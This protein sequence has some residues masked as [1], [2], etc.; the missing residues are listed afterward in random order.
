M[1]PIYKKTSYLFDLIIKVN[2]EPVGII[3][4][5]VTCYIGKDYNMQTP[6]ISLIGTVDL[7]FTGKVSFEF[8]PELTDIDAGQYYIQI[9]WSLFGTDRI[10][11]ILN[12]PIEVKEQI[13]ID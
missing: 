10:F 4:D 3:G 13:K 12:E 8:T 9:I 2:D 11:V 5:I 1:E 6:A 7:F